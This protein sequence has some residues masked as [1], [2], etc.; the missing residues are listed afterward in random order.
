MLKRCPAAQSA[1]QHHERLDGSDY[2]Q[3]LKALDINIT[4]ETRILMVANVVEDMSN[5]QPYR[6]A[7][8]LKGDDREDCRE[9]RQVLGSG[10]SYA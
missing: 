7:I 4:L 1:L 3:E 8:G 10:L 9:P 2:P 6:L 5:H